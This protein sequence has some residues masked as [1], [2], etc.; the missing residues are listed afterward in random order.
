M[1]AP[2]DLQ[3]VLH[4]DETLHQSLRRNEGA[5][6][7][8][9]AIAIDSPAMADIANTE[10]R[11]IVSRKKQVAEWR[12]KFIEPAKQ[13]IANAEALFDPALEA[14][15]NA[16]KHLKLLLAAWVRKEEERI[17]AERRAAEEAD[18]RARAE[19]EARAAA[20]RARAE[21]I[22]AARRRE[23]EEAEAQRRAASESGDT[24][25]AA[26]AAAASARLNQEAEARVEQAEV[27]AQEIQMS[28][29]AATAAPAAA[30]AA[31]KGF[32]LR[33]NWIAEVEKDEK[34]TILAIAAA[35]PTRPELIGLLKLDMSAAKQMA[36]AL[37][38][39]FNVPGMKA[40][41]DRVAT[42]RAA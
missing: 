16:E 5:L 39:N 25:T 15:E 18:R 31:P 20:E 4:M 6:E 9:K 29:P 1:N 19:A 17:A 35:L 36:R 3:V 33:D 40:K 41:N 30:P 27:K 23:A 42:S 10:L 8:A 34:T 37:K 28:A 32:G 21:E 24:R 38:A 14:L 13:I 7:E 12:K 26:A 22:A 11:D 2:A